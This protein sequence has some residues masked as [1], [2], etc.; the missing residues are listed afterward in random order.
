M[1]ARDVSVLLS[2]FEILRMF[3]KCSQEKK[4]FSVYGSLAL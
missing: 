2:A 3:R 1:F 4:M